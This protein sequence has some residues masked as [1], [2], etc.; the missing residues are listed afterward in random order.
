MKNYITKG[1][2]FIKKHVKKFIGGGVLVVLTFGGCLIYKLL[3]KGE[4]E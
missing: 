3:K 2:E 4:S 1:M